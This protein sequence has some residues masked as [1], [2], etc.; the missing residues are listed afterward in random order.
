MK[1]GK[2]MSK[3]KMN[4][5]IKDKETG[6]V[7]DFRRNMGDR[8]DDFKFLENYGYTAEATEENYLRRWGK[9]YVT[10]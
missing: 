5:I 7:V 10:D 9:W 4:V 1:N 2:R 6:R 8:V 3:N